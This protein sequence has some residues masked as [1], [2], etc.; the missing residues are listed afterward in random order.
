MLGICTTLCT[1]LES[2]IQHR[3]SN[4]DVSVFRLYP[5]A[6]RFAEIGRLL[7]DLQKMLQQIRVNSDRPELNGIQLSLEK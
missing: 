2:E 5:Q 6:G 3:G 1:W 7:A 4:L